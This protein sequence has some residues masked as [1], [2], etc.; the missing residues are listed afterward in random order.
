MQLWKSF[1]LYIFSQLSPNFASLLT[2]SISIVKSRSYGILWINPL[3]GVQCLINDVNEGCGSKIYLKSCAYTPRFWLDE[4]AHASAFLFEPHWSRSLYCEWHSAA[5]PCF[6]GPCASAHVMIDIGENSMQCY[7]ILILSQAVLSLITSYSLG[8]TPHNCHPTSCCGDGAKAPWNLAV[9]GNFPTLGL[10]IRGMWLRT[11]MNK[12]DWKFRFS[13][14]ETQFSFFLKVFFCC[15]FLC[16][17][18]TD[19]LAS[20]AEAAVQH[21]KWFLVTFPL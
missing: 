9:Q 1:L 17:T 16:L 8:E 13:F 10:L 2:D 21:G 11:L 4:G 6:K 14:K 15:W 7:T 18:G 19:P 3:P 5:I 12:V 20:V